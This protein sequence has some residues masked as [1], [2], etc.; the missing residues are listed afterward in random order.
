MQAFSELKTYLSTPPILT[1]PEEVETLLLY[2]VV[3]D[4]AVSGILIQKDKEDHRRVFYVKKIDRRRED[5]IYNEEKTSFS[6]CNS[7][8]ET[9]TILSIY[10]SLCAIKSSDDQSCTILVSLVEWP[11]QR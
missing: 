2:I 3:S 8:A 4:A 7:T 6:H 9:K 1:Q 5:Y 10:Y 11:N